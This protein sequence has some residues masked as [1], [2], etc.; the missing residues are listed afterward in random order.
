MNYAWMNE[1]SWIMWSTTKCFS[2]SVFINSYSCSFIKGSRN[3]TWFLCFQAFISSFLEKNVGSAGI[4]PVYC[5]NGTILQLALPKII[6]H[7]SS[8][9]RKSSRNYFLKTTGFISP[10]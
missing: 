8:K 4:V 9:L 5:N 6:I 7:G 10:W 2:L 1:V 3:L